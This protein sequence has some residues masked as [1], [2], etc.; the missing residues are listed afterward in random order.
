[1]QPF[2]ADAIIFYTNFKILIPMESLKIQAQKSLIFIIGFFLAL[3]CC[4]KGPFM[5]EIGIQRAHC[6]SSLYIPWP[7]A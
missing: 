6:L 4:L 3:A 7:K 2:S 1:M 5:A